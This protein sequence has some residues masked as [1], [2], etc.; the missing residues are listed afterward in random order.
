M[1]LGGFGLR[2]STRIAQS[3]EA[4]E[5]MRQIRQQRELER[6]LRSAP[7]IDPF[8]GS[9]PQDIYSTPRINPTEAVPMQAPTPAP[10]GNMEA[11]RPSSPHPPVAPPPV[12][13]TTPYAP[14][15]P[16]QS[17]PLPAQAAQP[18]TMDQMVTDVG[19]GLRPDEQGGLGQQ[20]NQWAIE[21]LKELGAAKKR[22][23]GEYTRLYRQMEES[24]DL[25]RLFNSEVGRDALE[26][27]GVRNPY[28]GRGVSG[29]AGNIMDTIIPPAS[30]ASSR[31]SMINR[32][33]VS[34]P[35]VPEVPQRT[36]PLFRQ[37]GQSPAPAAPAAAVPDT[38][39]TG[40]SSPVQAD[41][42]WKKALNE[43]PPQKKPE[44]VQDITYYQA[45]KDALG[46]QYKRSMKQT[47]QLQQHYQSK[48]DY[49]S[50]VAN[51]AKRVGNIN[52]MLQASQMA[53]GASAEARQALQPHYANMTYMQ[54]MQAVIDM[55]Y[56]DPSRASQLL[57]AYAGRGVEIAPAGKNS[58]GKPVYQV[59]IDGTEPKMMTENQLADKM[60]KLFS[61]QYRDSQAEANAQQQLMALEHQMKLD[62][63]G[64]KAV[65]EVMKEIAVVKAKKAH[66]IDFFNVPTEMGGAITI[67]TE[68]DSTG[69]IPKMSFMKGGEVLT[70]AN[71]DPIPSIT[72]K[73]QIVH[74]F[75]QLKDKSTFGGT[76]GL[77]ID[78]YLIPNQ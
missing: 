34:E 12:A 21:K 41:P 60:Q 68:W 73:E 11:L 18:M 23:R 53:Y 74:I 61:K 42:R 49:Y 31:T 32:P 14:S 40:F 37:Q 24:G 27:L 77:S 28:E 15:P 54:G 43:K 50:Y 78:Q 69:T 22:D 64:V 19:G 76:G 5:R 59:N 66:E 26:Q 44:P 20:E 51:A 29:I 6:Q 71:G 57:T 33:E 62:L 10:M 1:G 48:V 8:V 70:D 30:A 7:D 72:G 3:H 9:M 47:E 17:S 67:K 63:E 25:Q 38:P 4:H 2:S 52:L 65:N 56:G 13:T 39:T 36:H 58:K 35:A 45:D 55:R 16:I 46:A 75:R